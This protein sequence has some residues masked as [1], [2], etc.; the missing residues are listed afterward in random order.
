MIQD[1]VTYLGDV[2]CL[3]V[4][5]TMLVRSILLNYMVPIILEEVNECLNSG[6]H[7]NIK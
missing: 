1:A 4:G 3:I 5:S 2:Y 6:F 7:A